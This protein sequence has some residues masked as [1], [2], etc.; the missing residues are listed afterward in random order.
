MASSREFLD[1]AVRTFGDEV[2]LAEYPSDLDEIVDEDELAWKSEGDPEFIPGI[3]LRT[4]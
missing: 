2:Q 3:R 4:M 1:L